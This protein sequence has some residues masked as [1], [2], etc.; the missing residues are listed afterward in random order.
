[1]T[2]FVCFIDEISFKLKSLV[3]YKLTESDLHFLKASIMQIIQRCQ[4]CSTKLFVR[5]AKMP[6]P[7]INNIWLID[8]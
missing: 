6:F 2:V 5:K 8:L 1:M 4:S 7:F 3:H